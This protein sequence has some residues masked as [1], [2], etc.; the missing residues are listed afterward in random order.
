MRDRVASCPEDEDAK[1]E[2]DQEQVLDPHGENLRWVKR[3]RP[4]HEPQTNGRIQQ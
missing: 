3:S 2:Q 4:E 1:E